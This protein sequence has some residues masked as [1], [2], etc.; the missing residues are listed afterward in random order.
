MS[1]PFVAAGTALWLGVLTSISPCPLAS[2]IAAVSFIAK[3][4]HSPGQVWASGALYSAGRALSYVLVGVVVVTSVL[5][6][7]AV[8]MFLQR[9]MNRVLGP[10]LIAMGILM[11]GWLRLPSVRFVRAERWEARVGQSGPLGSG[12]LGVVFALSFCPVSAGLFFGSLLP[13]AMASHSR[14]LLPVLYGIGTGLPVAV[15]ALCISGSTR[16]LSR[17]FAVLTRVEHFARP[18]TGLVFLLAGGYLVLTH[19]FRLSV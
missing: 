19:W 7:P 11:F 18:A 4:M 10:L 3:H 6:V 14:I 1:E 16:A 15:V 8:S 9:D 13:L 5:S 17:S 2:N 12:L